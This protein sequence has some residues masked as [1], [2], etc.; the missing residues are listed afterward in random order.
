MGAFVKALP[1]VGEAGAG[2]GLT[3]EQILAWAVEHRLYTRRWPTRWANRRPAGDRPETW[4]DIDQALRLGLRGLP[5]RQSLDRLLQEQTGRLEAMRKEHMGSRSGQT[6]GATAG[7]RRQLPEALSIVEIL[8]W[9][10][11]HHAATGSWP[12]EGSGPVAGVPGETWSKVG[13]ALSSGTRG[14]PGGT[15]LSRLLHEHRGPWLGTQMTRLSVAEVLRW[16][17][18]HHQEH[19]VWPNAESGPV[20]RVPGFTWT[21]I[22]EL[23]KCGRRGLPGGLSLARLLARERW[24]VPPAQSA[25]LSAQ[26][27][28]QWADAH[29]ARFGKWPT[30]KSGPVTAAPGE[31]WNVI[32][33]ALKKGYRG[34]EGGSSLSQLLAANR[35][36]PP[37]PLSLELILRW[38]E[39]HRAATGRWPSADSGVIAAVPDETWS[40]VNS[41]L[42][43]GC[44]GLPGGMSLARLLASRRAP[45]AAT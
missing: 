33:V 13:S 31:W 1:R 45:G 32:D 10:D 30:A 9:A 40:K 37:R 20:D 28:L 36:S 29:H 8:A 38:A 22:D 15:T 14:L 5:G 3:V 44:R 16:A 4:Q 42:W 34:L 26:Q 2:T 23:L 39:A 7:P 35:S 25:G 43:R 12:R 41:A 24:G 27:I 19:G 11:A 6:E 21:K 17:D 18:R